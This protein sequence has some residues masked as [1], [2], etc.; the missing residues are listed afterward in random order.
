MNN[1]FYSAQELS[2]LGFKYCHES[3]KISRL[4]SI[5]SPET[6]SIGKASRIDDFCVLSGEI[7][8]GS[9]VH[10]SS[11]C[12]LFGKYGITLE[13][14]AGLSSRVTIYS[15][16]DDFSGESLVGPLVADTARNLDTGRVLISSYV[17]IGANSI[18]MPGITAGIGA[19]TGAFTFVK[20]DLPEWTLSI[21]IPNKILKN[22]S[23]K[24]LQL[25]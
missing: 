9:Q 7:S 6:I 22:R 25:L 4:A 17:Q 18:I 5:H 3:A 16:V 13:D 8:I 12:A 19:A 14:Y 20:T 23:K 1:T 10:I 15:A 21:G 2:Q 24:L 11:H